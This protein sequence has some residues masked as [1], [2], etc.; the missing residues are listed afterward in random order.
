MALKMYT[1]SITYLYSSSSYIGTGR[2]DQ[3]SRVIVITGSK[4]LSTV[5]FPSIIGLL[6]SRI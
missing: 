5:S 4:L 3:F 1:V 6:K 2:A